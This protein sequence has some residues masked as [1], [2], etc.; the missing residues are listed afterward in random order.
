MGKAA[1]NHHGGSARAGVENLSRSLAVEWAG[2]GIRVNA[3]A[4]GV[5]FSTSAKANY[6][7]DILGGSIP[8]I[9]AQRLGVLRR[10]SVAVTSKL[11]GV[12]MKTLLSSPLLRS[13]LLCASYSHQEQVLSALMEHTNTQIVLI[14]VP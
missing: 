7:V 6:D 12:L 10:L 14:V 11:K 2:D 3:V 8:G 13:P 9:P 5:V 1:G 4:P